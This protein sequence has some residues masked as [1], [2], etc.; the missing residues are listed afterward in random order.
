VHRQIKTEVRDKLWELHSHIEAGVRK[1]EAVTVHEAAEDWLTHGLDGHSRCSPAYPGVC[2]GA[3]MSAHITV[4]LTVGLRTEEVRALRW[5][6]VVP[7]VGDRWLPVTVAG[8][9][10][11]QLA[12]LVRR[13]VRVHGE[14]KTERSRRSLELPQ[15]R[16]GLT[17]LN[18]KTGIP[19]TCPPQRPTRRLPAKAPGPALTDPQG[20]C[21]TGSQHRIRT[22]G[23][24]SHLES[25]RAAAITIYSK[26]AGP[27]HSSR[28][29]IRF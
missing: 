10:H 27:G 4:S 5:D 7:R 29:V 18:K 2:P 19:P 13:S 9:D 8:F 3:L 12:V 24:G 21:A 22:A 6:H 11:E 28:N 26:V 14:T 1:P 25:N 20:P 17:S 16:L 23:V 15:D